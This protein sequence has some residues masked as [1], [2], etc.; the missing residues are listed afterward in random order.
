MS[1]LP[2]H[3]AASSPGD[4][5]SG[6]PAD[7]T[8]T[9]VVAGES[10][11]PGG[12][13]LIVLALIA[14]VF[15][16]DFSASFT[17]PLTAA[18]V[19]SFVLSPIV[20]VLRR[21]GIPRAVGSAL[22][23]F[24]LAGALYGGAMLFAPPMGDL[25]R[26][27]PEIA[28]Q[29]ERRFTGIKA[30]I[31][32]IKEADKTVDKATEVDKAK[33]PAAVKVVVEK[34]GPLQAMA[35][36]APSL[37]FQFGLS[38]VLLYFLLS[39][40]AGI[41]DSAVRT[42]N[43]FTDK[44]KMARI[45]RDVEQQ[46][47]TYLFTVT[48]INIGLGVATGSLLY[49]IGF[50]DAA[51]WGLIVAV[52]NFIPFIGPVL[53]ALAVGLLSLAEGGSLTAALAPPGIVLGLHIIESQFVSPTIVGK[54]LTMNPLLVF[55]SLGFWGWLWGPVGALISIPLLVIFKAICDHVE[56][57]ATV[58][59]LIG[60]SEEEPRQRFSLTD[61]PKKGLRRLLVLIRVIPAAAGKDGSAGE[62]PQK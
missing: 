29:L 58:G 17:L 59:A 53:V 35:K 18:V 9:K 11:R 31:K 44:L 30:A 23:V 43:S 37:F 26:K 47:S 40:L 39:A 50:K 46:C 54:R 5:E 49:L 12:R 55:V 62:K 52:F 51:L 42:R 13:S 14:T 33:G 34:P 56:Q 21:G 57:L 16:L 41:R 1:D 27:A 36:S 8:E 3:D 2:A 22:T 28:Q 10:A 7:G 32:A 20:R 4:Q 6:D 45:F 15:F 48:C 61:A 19:L 60:Y 24:A 38:L 25:F